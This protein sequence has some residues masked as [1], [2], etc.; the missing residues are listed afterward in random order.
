MGDLTKHNK[1]SK[2]TSFQKRNKIELGNNIKLN[3]EHEQGIWKL[4]RHIEK[5][6][7]TYP[8]LLVTKYYGCSTQQ[9]YLCPTARS[10]NHPL[11]HAIA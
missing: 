11:W 9:T 8:M 10:Y 5:C 7:G 3:L 1:V 4:R 6:K 2:W